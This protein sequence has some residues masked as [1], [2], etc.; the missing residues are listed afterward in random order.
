MKPSAEVAVDGYVRLAVNDYNALLHAVGTVGPVA[1]S[2]DAS[3]WHNYESG[4][5]NGCDYA[6]NIDIDHA[7]V[8][9]GYGTDE[10]FGDYWIIR[11]SWGTGYGEN[12]Y[13]RLAREATTLCGTDSTVHDGTVCKSQDEPTQVCG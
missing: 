9:V 8:L 4:V 6:A 12:G 3:H 11:N 7:V 2:V 10:A 5:F 1:V 13:I